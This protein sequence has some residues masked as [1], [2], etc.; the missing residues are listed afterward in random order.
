MR[1]YCLLMTVMAALLMLCSCSQE[2]S[3]TSTDGIKTPVR[4][5]VKVG[6]MKESG[7]RAVTRSTDTTTVKESELSNLW[8]FQ[9]SSTGTYMTSVCLTGFASSGF[10]VMLIPASASH[11]YFLA[12]WNNTMLS[13]FTG[14]E[15]AFQTLTKTIA[16]EGDVLFSGTTTSGRR[17]IPMNSTVQTIDVASTGYADLS[18]TPI[19]INYSVA[20]LNLI[21]N[22]TA[23]NFVLRRIRVCNVPTTMEF[24][25][26]AVAASTATFPN[27]GGILSSTTVFNTDYTD[28][29]SNTGVMVFYVPENQRGQSAGNTLERQKTGLSGDYTTYIELVGYTTANDGRGELHYRIYPGADMLNDYNIV[30][31]TQYNVTG[32]LIGTSPVDSRFS[33]QALANSYIVA[34]G[35]TVYIPVKRANQPSELGIQIPDLMSSSLSPYVYWQSVPGLVTAVMDNASGCMKVTASSTA[36]TAGIIGGNADIGV[37]TGTGTPAP[38]IWS[39][40]VWV[41][42]YNPGTTNLT[43]NGLVWMDR[44]L[45]ALAACTGTNTVDQTGGLSYE[46]GRKDPFPGTSSSLGGATTYYNGSTTGT[47]DIYAVAGQSSVPPYYSLLGSILS[48]LVYIQGGSTDND[49]YVSG[50]TGHNDNLWGTVKTVYDPCPSGWK[51]PANGSWTTTGWTNPSATSSATNFGVWTNNGVSSYYPA[52]GNRGLSGTMG[53]AANVLCWTSTPGVGRSYSLLV[54]SGGATTSSTTYGYRAM[55]LSIRCVKE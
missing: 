3:V 18:S 10:D 47:S 9:F 34:P 51:V 19:M 42:S 36:T 39:W 28:V 8:V 17:N 31:N 30:R 12:N 55:G 54:N 6:E 32:N 7:S 41:T 23:P 35:Q 37:T 44:N 4:F 26:P 46:W 48:P 29:T 5:S 15:T 1:R 25:P 20:K 40:H 16:A 11:V 2:L 49:W 53:S 38:A 27:S 43:Q 22:A 50:T 21:Y 33:E 13:T 14:T 24:Y 45:G 52:F